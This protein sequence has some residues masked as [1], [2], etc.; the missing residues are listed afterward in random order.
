[1]GI[2]RTSVPLPLRFSMARRRKYSRRRKYFR[3]RRGNYKRRRYGKVKRSVA[4]VKRRKLSQIAIA[5]NP[6]TLV[7][8]GG[9]F[10]IKLS[11]V[12]YYTEMTALYDQY[13]ISRVKVAFMGG[14]TPVMQTIQSNNPEGQ[15]TWL[16]NMPYMWA[17]IDYTDG[18]LP[19]ED[20][21]KQYGNVKTWRVD[22]YKSFYFKP[23]TELVGYNDQAQ[24]Q[25]A[26]VTSNRWI[27]CSQT[28]IQHYGLKF[29]IEPFTTTHYG[30]DNQALYYLRVCVTY[31]MK[32]KNIR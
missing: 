24:N 17:A 15:A 9:V 19:T 1:M 23:T 3:R 30:P 21:M 13:K 14:P 16:A 12:P 28:G 8:Q 29:F 32:F 4:Y 20:Q 31:Y 22:R 18:V 7:G 26:V 27:S 6:D 25:P 11:D 5:I 2:N 10:L